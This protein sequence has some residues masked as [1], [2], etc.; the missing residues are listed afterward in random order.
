MVSVTVFCKEAG[1]KTENTSEVDSFMLLLKRFNLVPW[2]WCWESLKAGGEG[3]DRGWD[4]WMASL[5]Q[6]T[7]VW[8]SSG[9]WWRTGRPGVLQSHGVAK[10]QT[11]LEW[12]N[13][14]ESCPQ[15]PLGLNWPSSHSV[16]HAQVQTVRWPSTQ[17]PETPTCIHSC[18]QVPRVG[19]TRGRS[20]TLSGSLPSLP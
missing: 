9:S 12:L 11:W 14:T 17:P 8:L 20:V 3:D 1:Y 4:G 2:P 16:R 5:T 7:W 18:A 19:K 13:W 10:S 6:W 15:I